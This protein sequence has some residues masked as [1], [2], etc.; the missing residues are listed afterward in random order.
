M[1]PG[2]TPSTPRENE[3]MSKISENLRKL[4]R[5]LAAIIATAMPPDVGRWNGFSLNIGSDLRYLR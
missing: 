2:K 3:R 5:R 1:Q 4:S